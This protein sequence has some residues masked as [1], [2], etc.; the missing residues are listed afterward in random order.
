MSKTFD[1]KMRMCENEI[2]HWKDYAQTELKHV[3]GGK[4]NEEKN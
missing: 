2:I 3:Y 4:N 1:K